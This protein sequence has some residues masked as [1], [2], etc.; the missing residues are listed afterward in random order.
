MS[1]IRVIMVGPLDDWLKVIAQVPCCT[2][3]YLPVVLS[4]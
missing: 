2:F 4:P 3:H 1:P